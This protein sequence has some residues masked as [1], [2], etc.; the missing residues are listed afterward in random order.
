MLVRLRYTSSQ[1]QF[2]L[3]GVGIQRDDYNEIQLIKSIEA[4]ED[5]IANQVIDALKKSVD[6]KSIIVITSSIKHAQI[7]YNLVSDQAVIIHSQLPNEKNK[8]S[9]KRFK[10][11]QVRILVSVIIASEG[12]DCPIASCLWF[13]R[14]TRSA[15]LYMQAAG[16]VV[17]LHESKDHALLLDYGRVYEN[18]GCIYD[19]DLG[20]GKEKK[21]KF[22]ICP[23]CEAIL[24]DTVNKCHCD[25]QF[26]SQCQYCKKDKPKGEKCGCYESQGI[27]SLNNMTDVAYE[28]IDNGFFIPTKV[29]AMKHKGTKVDCIKIILF[30]G[31]LK[32]YDIYL[33]GFKMKEFCR[34]TGYEYVDRSLEDHA[35]YIEEHL[36]KCYVKVKKIDKF[37]KIVEVHHVSKS[38]KKE[39]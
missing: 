38:D 6:H 24:K 7:V 33:H 31:V 10:D 1:S 17:R 28:Y 8:D 25:Y 34:I 23:M 35:T 9:M 14:P 2:D 22:V 15:R 27:R 26:M 36:K 30:K 16:R 37:N 39:C 29:R 20:D 18:L 21:K 3:S 5:I 4:Q 12:L 13:M 32:S 11:G 19:I